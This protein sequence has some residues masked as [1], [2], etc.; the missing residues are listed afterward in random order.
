MCN[1]LKRGVLWAGAATAAVAATNAFV[2]WNV[3]ASARRL[4]GGFRRTPA[5]HGDIAYSVSG[6]GA[7][8]LL[9]HALV[10]GNSSAEWEQNFEA[11]AA[12]FTVYA[13]DFLGWGWS[14]KP[15]HILR[16][17]DYAEQIRHFVEDVIGGDASTPCTVVASGES[18]TFALLAAQQAPQLFSRLVLVCPGTNEEYAAHSADDDSRD[19]K[20]H[21]LY[22]LLT[23][24]VFG[25][26]LLNALTS[27]PRLAAEIEQRFFN[28]AHA[29]SS[30]VARLYQAAH[31]PSSAPALAAHFAGVLGARW[32]DAWEQ[33]GL[34]TLL[35]WGREAAAF[36][37]AHEWLALKLDTQIEVIDDARKLPH[38]EHS[39][40]FNARVLD[41]LKV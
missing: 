35:V 18:C 22:K 31:Q 40:E 8:L 5:R 3:A 36:S 10:P 9:L 29:S 16:P 11:L 38:V 19:A 26:F 23:C 1:L 27:R 14:D 25:Q 32:Q 4:G 2:A 15:R 30:Y 28:R 39:A 13:P 6:S 24:P 21:P 33:L 41:W 17:T 34:P 20:L 37:Q 12:N 7:P